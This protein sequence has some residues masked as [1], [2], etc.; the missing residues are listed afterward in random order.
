MH[1]LE[2]FQTSPRTGTSKL[3]VDDEDFP[4]GQQHCLKRPWH[5]P[6]NFALHDTWRSV[7]W[8]RHALHAIPVYTTNN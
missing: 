1:V 3:I 7:Y 4:R 5:S 2:N 6:W 8:H